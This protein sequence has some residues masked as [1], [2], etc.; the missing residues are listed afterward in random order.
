MCSNPGHLDR[1]VHGIIAEE[2]LAACDE[3]IVMGDQLTNPTISIGQ[4]LKRRNLETFRNLASQQ[5]KKAQDSM[6]AGG[7]THHPGLLQRPAVAPL[8]IQGLRTN[9]KDS[10]S[11]VIC[12]DSESLIS[13]IKKEMKIFLLS[14]TMLTCYL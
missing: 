9:T 11:H 1:V 8:I 6:Q 12:F 5:L 13:K 10:D 4:A 14:D 3:K 7:A 2:I